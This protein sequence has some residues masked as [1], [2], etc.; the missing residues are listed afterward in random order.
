MF[1]QFNNFLNN[2]NSPMGMSIFAG[3]VTMIY[4]ILMSIN[5]YLPSV[6]LLSVGMGYIVYYVQRNCPNPNWTPGSSLPPLP[7]LP[8]LSNPNQQ[9]YK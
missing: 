2:F 3:V 1:N 8:P 5:S 4:L 9:I 7:P 6:L